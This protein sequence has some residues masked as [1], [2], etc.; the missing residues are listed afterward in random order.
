ME[1]K[2]DTEGYG[3]KECPGNFGDGTP[4]YPGRQSTHRAGPRGRDPM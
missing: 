3:P 1:R 4:P 2:R